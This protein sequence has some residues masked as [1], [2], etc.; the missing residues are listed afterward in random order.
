MLALRYFLSAPKKLSAS[1]PHT[2]FQAGY[3]GSVPFAR[4]PLPA[5]SPA[6]TNNPELTTVCLVRDDDLADVAG[7]PQMVERGGRVAE[8]E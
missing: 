7:L 8:P 5:P 1:V 6:P 3:E 4:T 2:A